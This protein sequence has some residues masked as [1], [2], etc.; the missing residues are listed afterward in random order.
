MMSDRETNKE[1]SKTMA[2][3]LTKRKQAFSRDS[4]RIIENN[5]PV[6]KEWAERYKDSV[7]LEDMRKFIQINC[8]GW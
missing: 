7:Y 2:I 5:G 6:Y 3:A 1:A 8:P 4:L